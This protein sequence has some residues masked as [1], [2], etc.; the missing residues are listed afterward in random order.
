L[1][2]TTTGRARKDLTPLFQ[3]RRIALVGCTPLEQNR[4]G[5]GP[6]RNLLRHGAS[7]E[8]YPV[9]PRYE[10]LEGL[11]CYP[12]LDA[13]PAVPDLVLLMIGSAGVPAALREADALGVGAAIAY[14]SGF[15]GDSP[16]ATE[17]RA[18]VAETSIALCGPNTNG[19]VNVA[20]RIAAGFAPFLDQSLPDGDVAIVSQSGALCSSIVARLRA[21]GLGLTATCAIGNAFDLDAGDVLAHLATDDATATVLVYLESIGDRT[22]F[23]DGVRA[24]VGA[25][26][27][28]TVLKGGRTDAGG[29]A[30]RNHTGSLVGRYDAFAALCRDLGVV[31][32]DSLDE[33]VAVPALAPMADRMTEP[34]P[35]LGIVCSSGAIACLLTDAA[36]EHGFALADYTPETKARLV[37]RLP[38]SAPANPYDLTPAVASDETLHRDLLDVFAGDPGIGA[39]VWGETAGPAAVVSRLKQELVAVADRMPVFVYSSEGRARAGDVLADSPIALSSS[40][41]VLFSTVRGLVSRRRTL[42]P[43]PHAD[44]DRRAAALTLLG[45]GRPGDAVPGGVAAAL[46]DPYGV[47]FAHERPVPDADAAVAEA[48]ALGFPV[49][50]KGA[51]PSIAHKSDLGLVV[52][53]V[54]DADA[55]R[56]VHAELTARL[57]ALDAAG[58]TVTVQPTAPPGVEVIVATRTDPEA[59]PAIVVGLGGIFTELLADTVVAPAPITPDEVPALLRGL[60][61]HGLLAGAR[62]RPAVDLA[63]LSEL[64]A[65]V[66]RL[67]FELDGALSSIELNPVIASPTGAVGVDVL[68]HH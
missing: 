63:A 29:V 39:L 19:F 59:G 51:A 46:L 65:A 66:S 27:V 23:V 34:D 22:S 49:V 35:R 42:R 13:L 2:P 57:A 67:G 26:K 25:G 40:P 43:A 56:R 21:Q 16:L 37:E 24:A 14:G 68:A 52:L 5:S 8:L 17:L 38:A 60:R 58:G 47:A 54:A 45:D 1:T 11:R 31:L 44:L 61:G 20:G 28:V 4:L 48:T 32:V 62:G 12:S 9:N 7:A 55:V 41:Q 10:E 6:F 3:P 30:A 33:L 64:V 36:V 53:G 15:E 18:A 50:L